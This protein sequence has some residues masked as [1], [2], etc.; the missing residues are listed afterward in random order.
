MRIWYVTGM[1]ILKVRNGNENSEENECS[2][3]LINPGN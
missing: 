2:F 1:K 3:F